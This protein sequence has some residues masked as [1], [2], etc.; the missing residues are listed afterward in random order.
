M[1]EFLQHLGEDGC[2]ENRGD[3]GIVMEDVCVR[4]HV[5]SR[6]E[7]G[8]DAHESRYFGWWTGSGGGRSD[9]SSGGWGGVFF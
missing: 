2:R 7:A 4:W 1:L 9:G 8:F 5:K 3:S 6:W